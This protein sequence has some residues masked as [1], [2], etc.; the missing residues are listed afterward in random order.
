MTWTF[1]DKYCDEAYAI[2]DGVDTQ[3]IKKAIDLEKLDTLLAEL[4]S[5]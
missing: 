5:S 1:F 2:I 3:K 4:S